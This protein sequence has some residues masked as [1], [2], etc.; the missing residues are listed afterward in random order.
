M[1]CH[2]ACQPGRMAVRRTYASDTMTL[3]ERLLA[4]I[5]HTMFVAPLDGQASMHVMSRT[6]SGIGIW[7][8]SGDRHCILP[9]LALC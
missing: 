8:S 9:L 2:R 4:V 3:Y 7:Y 6:P 1:P 5:I